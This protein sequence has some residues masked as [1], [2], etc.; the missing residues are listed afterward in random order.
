MFFQHT[1]MLKARGGGLE[2]T[3]PVCSAA[4]CL[5]YFLVTRAL[6]IISHPS[7]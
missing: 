1:Y 4:F 5:L 7:R 6:R 3:L 2:I